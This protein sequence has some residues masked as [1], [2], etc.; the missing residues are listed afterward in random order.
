MSSYRFWVQADLGIRGGKRWEGDV[1][2]HSSLAA[3]LMSAAAILR[4]KL[5]RERRSFIGVT[6]GDYREKPAIGRRKAES[7]PSLP[8]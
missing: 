8:P 6:D 1:E 2:E 5:R 7:Q 3:A 4:K